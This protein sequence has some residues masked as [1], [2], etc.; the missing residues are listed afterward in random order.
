MKF[1]ILESTW[2]ANYP[3]N[4]ISAPSSVPISSI[5]AAANPY[6][7]NP[8]CR[9]HH[10]TSGLV[11]RLLW[12][13]EWTTAT[14]FW[15]HFLSRQSIHWRLHSG[16]VASTDLYAPW[17][18]LLLP[19]KHHNSLLLSLSTNFVGFK[20]VFAVNIPAFRTQNASFQVT[21]W[22]LSLSPITNQYTKLQ[23]TF[24]DTHK[25]NYISYRNRKKWK[26]QSLGNAE[27]VSSKFRTLVIADLIFY[28]G[29]EFQVFEYFRFAFYWYKQSTKLNKLN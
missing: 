24:T 23:P 16:P 15:Q 26:N 7:S 6:P 22:I 20:K 14:P 28:R 4:I 21:P 19:T 12:Q 5:F 9:C 3:W 29:L 2:T 11:S 10:V 8:L 13:P 18:E 27:K 1:T 25:Q 17:Q